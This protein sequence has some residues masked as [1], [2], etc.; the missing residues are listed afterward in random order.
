MALGCEQAACLPCDPDT[1]Q[2]G[3]WGLGPR[4]GAANDLRWGLSLSPWS[5]SHCPPATVSQASGPP[6]WDGSVLKPG[7]SSSCQG[8]LR[9]VI[10]G[11]FIW[12]EGCGMRERGKK[13]SEL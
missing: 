11:H 2:G 3:R 5:P 10:Q 9:G 13:A 6:P 1:L 7:D 4:P 8:D 12:T